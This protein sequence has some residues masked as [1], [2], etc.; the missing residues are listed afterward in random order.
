MAMK[1]PVDELLPSQ[2]SG[3]A[4]EIEPKPH[5]FHEGWFPYELIGKQGNRNRGRLAPFVVE[6][7]WQWLVGKPTYEKPELVI[8]Q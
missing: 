7:V 1:G 4:H 6:R 2:K 8:V 5:Q 3:N